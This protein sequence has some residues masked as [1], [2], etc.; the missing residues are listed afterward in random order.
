MRAGRTRPRTSPWSCTRAWTCPGSSWRATSPTRSWWGP[1]SWRS[2]ARTRA[3]SASRPSSA[4]AAAA[5]RVEEGRL[6]RCADEHDL[7]A[8]FRVLGDGAAAR[9]LWRAACARVLRDERGRLR[10]ITVSGAGAAAHADHGGEAPQGGVGHPDVEHPW[11]SSAPSR[12]PGARGECSI[13]TS[14]PTSGSPGGHEFRESRAREHTVH[15][16]KWTPGSPHVPRLNGRALR[17]TDGNAAQPCGVKRLPCTPPRH[18]TGRR[19]AP[20][21]GLS[22]LIH[23]RSRE[24]SR[25]TLRAFAGTRRG[26]GAVL[27]GLPL[28]RPR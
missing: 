17:R 25:S 28:T 9:V 10:P 26:L 12:P 14:A 19:Q 7:T 23:A 1:S 4:L 22:P 24:R 16:L 2:C 21:I 6:V 8:A 18:G 3:G 15:V 27:L 13:W 11:T 20:G 5:A